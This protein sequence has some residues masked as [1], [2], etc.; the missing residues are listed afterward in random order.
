MDDIVK[1]TIV[2]A[3]GLK[4]VGY[5]FVKLNVDT[6]SWQTTA[7]KLDDNMAVLAW[8]ETFEIPATPS[9]T[10]ELEICRIGVCI[11]KV[12]EFAV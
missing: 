5:W 10:L 11:T 8:N 12:Y 1:V 2:E 3:C 7:Q 6:A 4:E 9:D